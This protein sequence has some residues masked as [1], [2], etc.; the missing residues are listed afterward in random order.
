M[1]AVL[2]TKKTQKDSGGGPSTH[3]TQSP[4]G[5]REVGKETRCLATAGQVYIGRRQSGLQI[6][7]I[8]E[9]DGRDSWG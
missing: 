5:T 4:R 6:G 8:A 1:H 3:L 7:K 9:F 2:T